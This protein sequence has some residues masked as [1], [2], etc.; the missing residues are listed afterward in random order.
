[1]AARCQV[2]A[3][4]IRTDDRA[5]LPR[6]TH[7][8]ED[9][10]RTASFPGLPPNGVVYIKSMDLGR[11]D[12]RT[13]SYL[14]ADRIDAFIRTVRPTRIALRPTGH[15]NLPAVWF[16][17][18]LEPHRLLT[19]QLASGHLPRAWFWPVAVKGWSARQPVA[20]SLQ[21]IIGQVVR[22]SVDYTRPTVLANLAYV[23]EPLF[24]NDRLLHLLQ[25][26]TEKPFRRLVVSL[27]LKTKKTLKPGVSDAG[28]PPL[29]FEPA[30]YA[31]P[32][33]G[34]AAKSRELVAQA[35]HLWGLEDARSILT[36]GLVMAGREE[37]I[38]PAEI[39]RTMI[40]VAT[41]KPTP[42]DLPPRY[43]SPGKGIAFQ[44]RAPDPT[45]PIAAN[46]AARFPGPIAYLPAARGQASVALKRENGRRR[47]KGPP[48]PEKDRPTDNT[49]IPSTAGGDRGPSGEPG[50]RPQG[51]MPFPA[52]P[53]ALDPDVPRASREP[54][55]GPERIGLDHLFAGAYSAYAGFPLLI[56][57]LARLGIE[58]IFEDHPGYPLDDLRET[59]L[60]RIAFRQRIPP[61]DPSVQFLRDPE[62]VLKRAQKRHKAVTRQTIFAKAPADRQ[63]LFRI[64][65]S[66]EPSKPLGLNP[67]RDIFVIA[68]CRY[69][70]NL[71]GMNVRELI[72]RPAFIAL[73]ETH[74]DITGSIDTLDIRVR[75][76]GLDV[77]PGWVPWLGRVVQIH[78]TEADR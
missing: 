67:V 42:P 72:R 14:L 22:I 29:S 38:G 21:E 49:Q 62:V 43:R 15:P 34:L 66:R 46:G 56:N 13:S 6:I 7:L 35:V 65:R 23:L 10:L 27:G 28:D 40:Q 26:L 44:P 70:R 55:T 74:L 52:R 69:I 45:L 47:F 75:L 9:A 33:D 71:A 3:L 78:Y 36:T 24:A 2:R 41:R 8:V 18:E 4:K 76:A 61:D 11:F 73:T 17:H 31:Y 48:A 20:Q 25:T 54:R 60:W 12:D 57:V 37:V 68:V 53:D 39:R 64:P 59:I 1:M 58:A 5:R 19:E 77:N 30:R 32:T 63:A 51:P 50:A 16:A